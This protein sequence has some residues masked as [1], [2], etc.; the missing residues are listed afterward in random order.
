MD[1]DGSHHGASP[2][3]PKMVIPRLN[4]PVPP[5]KPKPEI[6]RVGKACVNCRKRSMS[7]ALERMASTDA[8]KRSNALARFLTADNAK[9]A[10]LLAL[11][12]RI[13]KT[14]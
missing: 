7:S 2:G 12:S 11:M 3:P 8:L 9:T 6:Q 10:V 4:R 5:P 14:G 1:N 13:E